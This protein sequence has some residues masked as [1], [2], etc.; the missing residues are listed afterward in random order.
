M[1]EECREGRPNALGWWAPNENGAMFNG[2]WRCLQSGLAD[3]ALRQRI[4]AKFTE[5]AEVLVLTGWRMPAEQPFGFRGSFA[6]YSWA[7]APRLLFVCKAMHQLT[8][9]AV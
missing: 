2:P 7:G 4:V 6:S 3:D 8:G 5:V 1:P 9:A